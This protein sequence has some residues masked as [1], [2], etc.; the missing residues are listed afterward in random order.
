MELS[1]VI[2]VPSRGRAG[3]I[4]TFEA[5]RGN[6]DCKVEVTT[7]HTETAQYIRCGLEWPLPHSCNNLPQIRDYTLDAMREHDVVIMVD[8]DFRFFK[9]DSERKLSALEP[10][11]VQGMIDAVMAQFEDPKVGLVGVSMRGGNNRY[12]DVEPNYRVNGFLA[13]RTSVYETLRVRFSDVPVMEDFW[14]ELNLL[15]NGY[16]ARTIFN[17]AYDQP[18]SG[19]PG[20]CSTYRTNEMQQQ[21][22]EYIKSQFPEYV[23]VVK[24]KLKVGWGDLGKERYDIKVQWKKAYKYAEKQERLKRFGL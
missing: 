11:E 8:D 2:V 4:P 17:Y 5:L 19:A 20:G 23:T 12:P 7:H 15:T 3:K 24:K 10:A 21:T 1:K 13:V 6:V 22:A 18:C 16:E 14:Y 9:R